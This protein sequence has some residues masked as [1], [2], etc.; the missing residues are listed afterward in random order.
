M[1][2]D[3]FSYSFNTPK[4]ANEVFELLLTIDQWWS[5]LYE[6]TIKG[7]SQK[8]NDEF[9]F[10]A[11]EGAHYSKQKLVELVPN[12]KIVWLVTDSNLSFLNNTAEWNG[13]K[14]QFDL[15]TAE[16]N[17]KVTF[18]HEGLIPLIECYNACSSAWNGYLGN[19]EKRLN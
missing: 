7:K 6:E 9:T 14:I 5:G 15:S 8:V 4:T 13:S 16:N 2:K 17:T 10:N 12:K 3:H 19:L 18:T 11:G 1:K